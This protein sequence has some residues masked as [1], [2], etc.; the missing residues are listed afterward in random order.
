MSHTAA[1]E[2]QPFKLFS[3]LIAFAASLVIT[4]LCV[5]AVYH[6]QK[7]YELVMFD[8]L[9]QRQ[10]DSL[11]A[12]VENDLG[13][14]GS[15]ANFF[16]ATDRD[17]WDRFP[18]F[19]RNTLQSSK[20]LISLQ[21]MQK[22]AAEDIEKHVEQ[23]R[24]TFPN[25]SIFTVPKDQP[26]TFGYILQ[27]NKPVFIASD[28]YPRSDVNIS[29]L[30]FYSARQRFELILD[31]IRTTGQAN[32]SDKVRLLQDG[33][34]QSLEKTGLL[35]YHPVFDQQHRDLLG[36]VVG[37]V[38]ST[39][40]F[41]ELVTK[42]ATELD[43]RVRVVD[44]GFDAEDDPVLFQSEQWAQHKGITIGKK[45]SL[46][47]RDWVIEFK[48]VSGVSVW[49]RTVLIGLSFGGFLVSCLVAY[50]ALLQSREK[51]RLAE[52]LDKKTQ[53]L[54]I[55]VDRDALTQSYNRRAFNQHLSNAIKR[56]NTFSLISFDIDK[57][58]SIND[59]YGHMVGDEVLIHVTRTVEQCLGEG[60]E[61]YRIGGDEFTIISTVTAK[62]ELKVYVDTLLTTVNNTRYVEKDV[63]VRC[64]LSVGAAV[65][66][67]E[68]REAL[69][70]KADEQLYKSKGAG[71]NCASIA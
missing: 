68:N 64:S 11:L 61:L 3:P 29:L 7:R 4:A 57:F 26:K 56:N 60:D 10:A 67:G 71:R 35:V 33:Y 62:S 50:I 51:E 70:H 44:L 25:F 23:T 37:V 43:L 45:I 12:F 32:V 28:I 53:E 38:R 63:S 65:Y 40:Y 1:G 18:A 31:D 22:V 20:S 48:M 69:I 16:H 34:D 19:A 58:K 54:Q 14:I 17:D 2:Q 39:V 15:G 9:A 8:N 13:F 30:G 46:P 49:D 47:N 59:L 24:K 36:V 5:V 52:M 27:D 6:I 41:D 21:W 55:L 42:T 66:Q